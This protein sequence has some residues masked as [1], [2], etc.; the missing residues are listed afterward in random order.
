[1][2][3]ASRGMPSAKGVEWKSDGES[4]KRFEENIGNVDM[5]D[6]PSTIRP[7]GEKRG[8]TVY[9]WSGSKKTSDEIRAI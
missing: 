3:M 6:S 9:V 5:G 8:R 7:A 1:M 4:R 2:V